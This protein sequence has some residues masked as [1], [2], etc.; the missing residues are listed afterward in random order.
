MSKN[1]KVLKDMYANWPWFATLVDLLEMILVKSEEK[2][3]ENYDKQL[4]TEP[5]SLA[6]GKELRTRLATTTSAVL[7]VS[8]NPS[9]QAKNVILLR[10]L[11]VRNPYVDPL[12]ILQAE[13]LRRLR[14]TTVTRSEEE[15]NILQ[16][17]L[18]ITIN[19][20]ANGM[21]NSG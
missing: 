19:G 16:D 17:A 8:G 15:R 11:M 18:L 13:L 1:P 20:I 4:V 9:L 2:I 6:L 7:K 5:E 12:N 10:S 21:R 14:D 3:A